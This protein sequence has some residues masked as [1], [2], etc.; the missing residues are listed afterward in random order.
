MSDKYENEQNDPL[1]DYY[2]EIAHGMNPP[3]HLVSRVKGGVAV[4]L[5]P[6]SVHVK[7][8]AQAAL[9]YVA[10]VVLLLSA[11]I[12]LPKLW[13]RGEPIATQPS[14]TE[15]TTAQS[16]PEMGPDVPFRLSDLYGGKNVTEIALWN[17][18]YR[19]SDTFTFSDSDEISLLL[20]E[21]STYMV[22]ERMNGTEF[23]VSSRITLRLEEGGYCELEFALD[24]T[25]L[26]C[27]I[28]DENR[29]QVSAQLF[30]MFSAEDRQRLEQSVYKRI[31]MR[32]QAQGIPDFNE[33]LDDQIL[34]C[35]LIHSTQEKDS[36]Y[37][38]KVDLD[39]FVSRL[40]SM[41][42][43]LPMSESPLEYGQDIYVIDITFVN[44]DIIEIGIGVNTGLVS[45]IL[46]QDGVWSQYN[47]CVSSDAQDYFAWLNEYGIEYT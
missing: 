38:I 14:E 30:G 20:D 21:L 33:I 13:E 4:K 34:G 27:K 42:T 7:R 40:K 18:Y 35:L 32:V 44:Q 17:T 39:E 10:G 41:L 25:L 36:Q 46:Q 12:L 23:K 45:V 2:R 16:A 22:M 37:A 24:D 3:S 29:N 28:L 31:Q 6:K 8:F 9:C 5:L 1:K 47:F 15:G 19:Y 43:D 26:S 11:V